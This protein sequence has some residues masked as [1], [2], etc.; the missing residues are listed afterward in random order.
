[1]KVK[2]NNETVSNECNGAKASYSQSTL[3][4]LSNKLKQKLN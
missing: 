3:P 2:E 1:M 4:N